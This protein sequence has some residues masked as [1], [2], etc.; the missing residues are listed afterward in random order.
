MISNTYD[1]IRNRLVTENE[2]LREALTSIQREL[3]EILEQKKEIFLKRRRIEIGDE[4]K[5]EFDFAQSTLLNLKKDLFEM[6][7]QTVY[8][9]NNKIRKCLGW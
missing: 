8:L 3:S 9:K 4:N 5:E 6:P 2:L 7:M 1:D